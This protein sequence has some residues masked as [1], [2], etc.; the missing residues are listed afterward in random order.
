MSS[1][2]P[3]TSTSPPYRPTN[4]QSQTGFSGGSDFILLVV[5]LTSIAI[6]LIVILLDWRMNKKR[7]TNSR[8]EFYS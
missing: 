6:S 1:P 3:L 5:L 2:I 8:R 4:T 7:S